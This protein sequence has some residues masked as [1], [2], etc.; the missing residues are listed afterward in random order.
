MVANKNRGKKLAVYNLSHHERYY[1]HAKVK[2]R[3]NRTIRLN[4]MEVIS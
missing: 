2:V 4:P 1:V 3:V